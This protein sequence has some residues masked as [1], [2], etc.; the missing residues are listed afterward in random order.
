MHSD[1]KKINPE[2]TSL[3]AEVSTGQLGIESLPA[4][5]E[6]YHKAHAHSIQ[7]RNYLSTHPHLLTDGVDLNHDL[8]KRLDGCGE[9]LE[10][11]NYHTVGQVLLSRA[12]FCKKHLLCPLCAIRRGSKQVKAYLERFQHVQRTQGPFQASLVTLTVKNGDDLRERFE[13]LMKGV[14][15]LNQR[16]RD[17]KRY[18]TIS[19]WSKVL[20]LV[21][22]YETANELQ[23]WHPHTHIFV[24]HREPFLD[25]GRFDKNGKPIPLL[26]DEW[27]EITGDSFIVDVSPVRHPDDPARDL[28]EVF[29]YAV[30]FSSMSPEKVVQAYHVLSNRRLIFSAGLLWG[31]KVP[32]DLTDEPLENLPYHEMF[33]RYI[34]GNGYNLQ[35]YNDKEIS[36]DRTRA[37]QDFQASYSR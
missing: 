29:K 21:G 12:C 25:S 28:V 14:K 37:G 23:G 10:F 13:H 3:A 2:E 30:K 22:T 20:G 11:R 31:V 15:T 26:A 8:A 32:E 9:W 7:I 17:S 36:N 24:L 35:N 5:L 34:D 6:R 19:E 33:Y 16:R 27:K 1:G 4:R 18:A